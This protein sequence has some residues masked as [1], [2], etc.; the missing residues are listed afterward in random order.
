MTVSFP[1][2]TALIISFGILREE[3]YAD[4]SQVSPNGTLTQKT[5]WTVL[6]GKSKR[7]HQP[8][9]FQHIQIKAVFEILVYSLSFSL[10]RLLLFQSVISCFRQ[11]DFWLQVKGCK[12]VVFMCWFLHQGVRE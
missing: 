6:K 2:G 4:S 3:I 9:E 10:S 8:L 11:N 12:L 1:G 7:R 5:E